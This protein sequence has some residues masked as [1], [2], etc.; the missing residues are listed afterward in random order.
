[1]SLVFSFREIE[2]ESDDETVYQSKRSSQIKRDQHS[3]LPDLS[4]TLSNGQTTSNNSEHSNQNIPTPSSTTSTVSTNVFSSTKSPIQLHIKPT[5][6]T[7]ETLHGDIENVFTGMDRPQSAGANQS[8][9]NVTPK[10][11][12][13]MVRMMQIIQN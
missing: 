8:S 1:M 13:R 6:K 12:R 9:P 10:T 5:S 7:T 4:E 2:I 3:S 11:P